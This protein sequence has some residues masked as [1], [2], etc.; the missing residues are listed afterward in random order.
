VIGRR[1]AQAILAAR[2]AGTA[3]GPRGS[4]PPGPQGE[5]TT[6]HAA[7]AGYL[8][9]AGADRRP[10]GPR[11]EPGPRRRRQCIS[12]GRAHRPAA[13]SSGWV[14]SESPRAWEWWRRDRPPGPA[15]ATSAGR[16]GGSAATRSSS[17]GWSRCW[18]RWS[19]S[20]CFRGRDR[21]VGGPGPGRLGE[22]LSGV[23]VPVQLVRRHSPGGLLAAG[24][25][26]AGRCQP[27][28]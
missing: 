4:P 28:T 27:L 13:E 24:A 2:S 10:P 15:R 8:A 9:R 25:V 22:P 26:P 11:P 7:G 6:G 23:G 1:R 18:A 12:F 17:A 19:G 21:P 14:R 20:P 3:V 16:G 5:P